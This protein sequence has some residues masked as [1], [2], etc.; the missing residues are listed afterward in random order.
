MRLMKR[1]FFIFYSIITLNV[2]S[3]NNL[4]VH[5]IGGGEKE[6]FNLA[7]LGHQEILPE[8]INDSTWNYSLNL[9]YPEYLYIFIDYY[10]RWE[11][12]IW[13]DPKYKS[14]EI[15]IDY[16]NKKVVVSKIIKNDLKGSVEFPKK[17]IVEPDPNEWDQIVNT[18]NKLQRSGDYA[19]EEKIESAFIEMYPNSYEA[20]W[21]FTHSAPIYSM[22]H[23]KKF[24]LFKKLNVDLGKFAEYRQAKADLFNRKYPKIG[25]DFIDFRLIDKNQ[26]LIDSKIISNKWILLHFWTNECQASVNSLEPLHSCYQEVDTSK[27]AFI[28]ISIENSKKDWIKSDNQK[29]ITW[30]S[31]WEIDN[32]FGP[33][34]LQYNIFASPFFIL[35]DDKKKIFQLWDGNEIT[36][37]REK[38]IAEQLIYKMKYNVD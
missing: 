16:S 12:R 13:F 31:L 1:F 36:S 21:F 32:F 14:R 24:S 5:Q 19:E 6:I 9:K 33:L 30:H 15:Y 25:D 26:K 8:K 28:S 7:I 2:Y 4:V 38:L 37:I 18:A 22:E 34:C 29:Y 23:S 3:Q 11:E 27:I 35:F 20:L 17:I 10:I